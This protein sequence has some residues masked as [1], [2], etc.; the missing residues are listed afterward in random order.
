MPMEIYTRW[1]KFIGVFVIP[2]FVV[3]NFPPL[4]VLK[5][6]DS[7]YFAWALG[8]PLALLY[9]VRFVWKKGLKSYSSASS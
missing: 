3:S 6:M 2:I 5:K 8:L 1:I 7:I 9:V 4:F